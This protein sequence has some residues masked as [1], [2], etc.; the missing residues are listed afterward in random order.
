MFIRDY[1]YHLCHSH[2]HSTTYSQIIAIQ[3]QIFFFFFQLGGKDARRI[4]KFNDTEINV[5][6]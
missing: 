1:G 5:F 3:A 2:C 4:K 6:V